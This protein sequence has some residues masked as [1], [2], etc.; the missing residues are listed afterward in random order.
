LAAAGAGSDGLIIEVHNDP[1]HAL[2]DGAQCIRP[3]QFDELVKKLDVILP[4]VGKTRR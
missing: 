2:C 1:E 4:V 3:V